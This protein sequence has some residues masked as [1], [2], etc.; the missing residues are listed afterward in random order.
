MIDK[1]RLLLTSIIGAQL[2][3]Y[4]DRLAVPPAQQTAL[5][6]WLVAGIPIVYHLFAEYGP[7][8]MARVF[9]PVPTQPVTTPASKES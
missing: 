5:V 4:L 9:P 8:I 1:E 7:R 6:G 2:G 3:P